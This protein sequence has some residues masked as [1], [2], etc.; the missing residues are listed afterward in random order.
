MMALQEIVPAFGAATEELIDCAGNGI[1]HWGE[2]V[3]RLLGDGE[4]FVQQVQNSDRTPQIAILLAGQP[5]SGKTALAATLA[6]NSGFPL[7]KLIG[8]EQMVG[9]SEF[10]KV[11][12]INKLFEDAYKSK[13]SVIVVDEIERLL[14]YVPMGQR[15]TNSVLQ[16]LLVLFKKK[17]PKGHKLL[18]IGTTSSEAVLGTMGLCDCFSKIMH[19]DNL[20]DGEEVLTVV[21][22]VGAFSPADLK[23]LTEALSHG[24]KLTGPGGMDYTHINIGIKKLYMLIET[25]RQVGKDQAD[26]FLELLFEEC[27]Y[28]PKGVGLS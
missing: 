28:L 10:A 17:P 15:F 25:A 13:L 19:V 8:P 11:N 23:I 21:K 2:S 24:S 18:V 5:G 27:Q 14:D 22:E 20:T 4:L 16:A 6:Q 12:R 9:Y 7:I 26:K 1:V 3:Q